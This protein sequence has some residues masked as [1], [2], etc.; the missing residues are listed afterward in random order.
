MDWIRTHYDRVTVIAA[1]SF[2]FISAV[3]IWWSAVQFGNNLIAHRTAPQPKK[4][5]PPGKALEVDHAA[6]QLQHPAQWKSSGRSGLF[7][8]EK[9]FIGANGLPATLQN[10]Q[11]H[12]P[13][14]NDW[15][16]KFGLPI[17]DADVLE[18]DPDTD[19]FTNLDEWQGG[20]IQ[21]TR[22]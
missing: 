3:S 21:Q 19:G 17:Q 18:Q 9:H 7:V 2:L 1:A 10:T 15:F 5:A 11:V 14:P 13:V 12:A 8:P 16:E 22:I 6:E 20:T 4:A